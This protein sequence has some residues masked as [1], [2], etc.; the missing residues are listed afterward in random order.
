ME[1]PLFVEHDNSRI[2]SD[3]CLRW[4]TWS[5][6]RTCLWKSCR[7]STAWARNWPPPKRN[8]LPSWSCT[9]SVPRHFPTSRS[10]SRNK[11]PSTCPRITFSRCVLWCRQCFGWQTYWTRRLTCATHYSTATNLKFLFNFVG[12][13]NCRLENVQLT[14]SFR[15]SSS[16]CSFLSTHDVIVE[17]ALAS[18]T[19]KCDETCTRNFEVTSSCSSSFSVT[20]SPVETYTQNALDSRQKEDSDFPPRTA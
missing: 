3:T 7:P 20:A 11:I 8:P 6:T 13:Y 12:T 19:L 17:P 2:C 4:C 1:F 10:D 18:P 16:V 5:S 9:P 14:H 15:N